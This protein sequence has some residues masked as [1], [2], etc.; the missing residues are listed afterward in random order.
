MTEKP[1]AS[2]PKPTKPK[3]NC[4]QRFIS[5][6]LT[7]RAAIVDSTEVVR[8]MQELQ[9]S[10]PLPTVAVGRAMTGALL[11]AAQLKSGQSVGVH[12]RGNGALG[13]IYAESAFEGQVRGFTHNPQYQPPNYDEGLSLKKAI[14]NGLLTVTRHL[15]FQKEPHTG[16]VDLV[17]GE[18][19]DDLA[20]YLLQSHQVRSM[21]A[22]GVSVNTQ[23]QVETAGGLLLEVMP[24]VE[25]EI[26]NLVYKNQQ[27]ARSDVSQLLKEGRSLLE[28]L[29]P[30]L[31]GIPFTDLDHPYPVQYSCPCDKDRVLRA[32]EILGVG[33]LSEMVQEG[34]IV[35]VTCQM[36]GKP[37]DVTVEELKDI[38]DRVHRNSLN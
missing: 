29:E 21:V 20:H 24:G 10:Y 14:G 28:I 2:A 34:E 5:T 35:P 31:K 3:E 38:R 22:L 37:Y 9:K 18:V 33:D 27:E 19:G 8:A 16:T 11:M 13:T 1:Q 6:D 26:V 23:G 30:L 12:I 32:I 15:P 36:C 7:L 17:S 4:V 25:D